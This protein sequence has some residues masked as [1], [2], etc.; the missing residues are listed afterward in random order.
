[1]LVI[2]PPGKVFNSDGLF[3]PPAIPHGESR[4]RKPAVY[5]VLAV[6]VVVA[7]LV[8][9][10][11]VSELYMNAGGSSASSASVGGAETTNSVQAA[12]QTYVATYVTSL[13]R[14]TSTT[15]TS[16]IPIVQITTTAS[17]STTSISSDTSSYSTSTQ[18]TVTGGSFTYTSSSQ[19]RILSVAATVSNAEGGYSGLVLSVRF[20][21]VGSGTI[22]VSGGAASSLNATILSGATTTRAAGVRCEMAIAL[23]P[24]DP[25]GE[26]TSTTPSCSSGYYYQVAGPGTVQVELTLSWS[27]SNAGSLDI[28]A[29]FNVG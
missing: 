21:N 27:G 12:N 20:E 16:S 25:G 18:A 9:A 15:T 1:M 17:S 23:I 8:L 2:P 4:L 28:Y 7:I 29:Q 22:Y 24:I 6:G 19:V 26:Y 13:N 11:A 14:Q 3:T 10:F 5:T